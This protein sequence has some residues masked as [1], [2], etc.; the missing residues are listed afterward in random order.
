MSDADLAANEGGLPVGDDD[1][2]VEG[3]GTDLVPASTGAAAYADGGR[4]SDRISRAEAARRAAE[5]GRAAELAAVDD[6]QA[7]DGEGRVDPPPVYRGSGLGFRTRLTLA[8]IAAA[9][10]PSPGS[11]S[12]S[13][14]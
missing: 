8:L 9:V 1:A 7:Q 6:A 12:C 11:A 2:A 4:L 3:P 10:L 13:C 5:A 14:W